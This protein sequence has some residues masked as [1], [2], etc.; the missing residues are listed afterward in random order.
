VGLDIYCKEDV[1][2]ALLAAEE[3]SNATAAALMDVVGDPVKLRAYREGYRAALATV[4]LAFGLSPREGH[5]KPE[6]TLAVAFGDLP[7]L[8]ENRKMLGCVGRE[9]GGNENKGIGRER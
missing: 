1:A 8:D 5:R 7:E 9:R 2:N 6:V 4:A 3:A